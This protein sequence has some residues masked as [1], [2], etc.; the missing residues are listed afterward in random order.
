MSGLA[1]LRKKHGDGIAD[2]LWDL[3]WRGN[4]IIYDRVAKYGIQ[5]DIKSGY[6]EVAPKQS[7]VAWFD[8]QAEERARPKL[9]VSLRGMGP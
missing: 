7:Q 8:E 1:K 9:P 2:M 5:C 3:R 6:V 4:E